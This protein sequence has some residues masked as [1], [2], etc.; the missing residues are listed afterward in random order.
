[1]FVAEGEPGTPLYFVFDVDP[2]ELASP[3]ESLLQRPLVDSDTYATSGDLGAVIKEKVGMI[4][5]SLV[6]PIG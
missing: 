6:W 1:M 3:C 5:D 2:H 4:V